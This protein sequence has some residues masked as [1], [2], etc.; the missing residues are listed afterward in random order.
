MLESREEEIIKGLLRMF[1]N[2]RLNPETRRKTAYNLLS[3]RKLRD[4]NVRG[5]VITQQQ[6]VVSQYASMSDEQ[7]DE[8]IAV[9]M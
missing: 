1:K 5:M 2:E 3:F 9:K 4:V 7:S 6:A 8:A